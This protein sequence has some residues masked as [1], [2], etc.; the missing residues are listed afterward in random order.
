MFIFGKPATATQSTLYEFYPGASQFWSQ[1]I[2]HTPGSHELLRE[3]DSW[4]PFM[5]GGTEGKLTPLYV[6]LYSIGNGRI[7]RYHVRYF[8]GLP[9]KTVSVDDLKIEVPP[10]MGG[11]GSLYFARSGH[12]YVY[13]LNRNLQEIWRYPAE[14]GAGTTI[15][16]RVTLS[17]ERERYAYLLTQSKKENNLVRIDTTDGAAT[18]IALSDDWTG[19]HRPLVV[20]GPDQ[21]YVIVAAY[22]HDGGTLSVYSGGELVWQKS[23]TVS[24]PIMNRTGERVF[25]IQKGI[26]H[27]Y[28]L[29]NGVAVCNSAE[30]DLQADSN[31]VLDADDN[32][33]LWS[34]GM[35]VGYR[36]NCQRFFKQQLELPKDL[37]LLFASDGTFYARTG[38]NQ[39]YSI[40]PSRPK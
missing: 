32:L 35:L 27:E 40:T 34:N 14:E 29:L 19:F 16:S 13:G 38:T 36:S 18:T 22:N 21:D 33:Y 7:V 2:E 10:T 1:A 28:N 20:N 4:G 11:D 15:Q 8:K 12:G 5:P 37:E 3:V 25:A 24:Q 9:F 17:P 26:L 31:P 39:F 23:G 30:T 6:D